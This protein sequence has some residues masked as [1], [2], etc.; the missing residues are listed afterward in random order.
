MHLFVNFSDSCDIF[1]ASQSSLPPSRSSSKDLKERTFKKTE[2]E[3]PACSAVLASLAGLKRHYAKYH[4]G[5]AD[6]KLT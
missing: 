4:A 3:C 2:R 5:H 6:A 1:Q